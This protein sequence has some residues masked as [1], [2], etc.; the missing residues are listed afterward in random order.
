MADVP[1]LL[2]EADA[3]ARCGV[4]D[5]EVWLS[6]VRAGNIAYVLIGKRRKY[7]P[8]DIATFIEGK[9]RKWGAGVSPKA[10]RGATGRRVR[11]TGTMTSGSAVIGIEEAQRRIK[12]MPRS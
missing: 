5:R 12:M 2:S 3:M 10:R 11:S 1:L 8:E 6:E 4:K 7:A 9:R